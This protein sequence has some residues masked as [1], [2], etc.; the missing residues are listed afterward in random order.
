M[1][2]NQDVTYVGIDDTRLVT[3]ANDALN[4]LTW[5]YDGYS[6]ESEG[7][8]KVLLKTVARGAETLWR[9]EGD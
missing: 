8:Y 2:C 1:L 7:R 3:D 9:K 5:R 6:M 4:T